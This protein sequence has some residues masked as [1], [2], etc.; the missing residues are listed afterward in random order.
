VGRT[1]KRPGQ[2]APLGGC[3][4]ILA[5]RGEVAVW[6]EVAIVPAHYDHLEVPN[7]GALH[8][9]SAVDRGALLSG[10][11][12]EGPAFGREFDFERFQS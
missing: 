8:A 5:G 12:P 10:A 2:D 1:G 6:P 3:R 4:V 9:L 7:A 11:L